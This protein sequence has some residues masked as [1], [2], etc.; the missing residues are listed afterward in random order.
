M[1]YLHVEFSLIFSN[2]ISKLCIGYQGIKNMKCYSF[3]FDQNLP[4]RCTGE[5]L[6]DETVCL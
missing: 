6:K 3:E 5:S 2:H 4:L 1:N